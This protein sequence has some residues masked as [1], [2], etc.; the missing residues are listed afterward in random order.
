M[1][2]RLIEAEPRL[3]ADDEEVERIAAYL[4]DQGAPS[5]DAGITQGCAAAAEDSVG[6]GRNSDLYGRAVAIVRGERKASATYLQRR[7]GLGYNRAAD[8]MERMEREGIV[9]GP[10]MGGRRQILRAEA[11][12]DGKAW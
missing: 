6:G 10:M 5:Y 7:L 2:D 4:R 8:L 12:A 3:G 1:F 11:G 9:S